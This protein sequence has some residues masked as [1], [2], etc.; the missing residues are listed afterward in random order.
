MHKLGLVR[1]MLANALKAD[2]ELFGSLERRVMDIVWERGEA[3]VR[4][5]H[6]SV[7]SGLAYTTVMTTLD[8]LYRKGALIRRK[9]GRAFLYSAS[10]PREEME[11]SMLADLLGGVLAKSKRPLLSSLVDELS[12][13]DLVLLDELESLVREKRRELRR[14]GE[15]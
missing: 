15:D 3:S 13:R 2:G 9:E 1:C 12:R 5:V 10:A 11:R 7:D 8:R 4:D 6:A 14:K